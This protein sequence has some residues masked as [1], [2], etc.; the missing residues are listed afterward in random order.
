MRNSISEIARFFKDIGN[1]VRL[2]IL[3]FLAEGEKCICEILPKFEISQPTMSRHL[4]VLREHSI[5]K[6]KKEANKTFYTIN[7]ERVFSVLKD[8][9]LAIRKKKGKSK[10]QRIN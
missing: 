10:C 3:L 8:V 5:V 6:C 9:G 1:P 2:K 7:D 4:A